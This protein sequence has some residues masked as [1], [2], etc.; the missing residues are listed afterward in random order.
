M[1]DIK[2]RYFVFAQVPLKYLDWFIKRMEEDPRIGKIL[3]YYDV[4]FV[5]HGTEFY[6]ALPGVEPVGKEVV[7]EPS[8]LWIGSCDQ[9]DAKEVLRYV[10]GSHP[11]EVPMVYG[12][13]C[14]FV[15]P[16]KG[17]RKKKH[18]KQKGFRNH[19]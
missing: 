11:W 12:R 16:T 10:H 19:I 14:D 1:S 6:K 4:W 2:K 17:E 5:G 15:V 7:K 8:V 9:K 18:D 3:E 13:E